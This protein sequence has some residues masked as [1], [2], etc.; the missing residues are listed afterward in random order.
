MGFVI[1]ILIVED[2]ESSVK[3]LIK[4]LKNLAVEFEV[5]AV[6]NSVQSVLE[7]VQAGFKADLIFMDIHITDGLSFEIFKHTNLS[8]P[9]IFTTA[10]DEY[11]LQ[12]F[13]VKGLDY[14]LK[15]IDPLELE[16]AI[17]HFLASYKDLDRQ[18]LMHHLISLAKDYKTTSYRSSFLVDFKQKMH[19]VDVSDVAYF[20][21]KER[22]LF[23]RKKDQKEY[24]IEFF[25]D[26]L[27]KQ[28]DPTLFYRAN[29]QYIVARSVIEE[30]EPYFTGRLLLK[31]NPEP[32]YPIVI[33]KEKASD[34]KRW[35]DY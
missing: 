30:I 5:Q 1:K 10:Y 12:A 26:E 20:Y 3:R 9:V 4:E 33:S 31:V 21:V 7:W 28:L 25:L 18:N 15:P 27:E 13:K 6:L 22:G 8:I 35:A 34:F 14:L 11:A 23:L 19:L 2:E 32:A 17:N 29:R 16:K 24:V